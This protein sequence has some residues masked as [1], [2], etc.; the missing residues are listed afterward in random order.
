MA[1]EKELESRQAG[2]HEIESKGLA[3]VRAKHFAAPQIEKMIDSLTSALLSVKD[4]ASVRRARLQHAVDSHEYYTEAA[5]AEQWI[6]DQMLVAINQETGRDQASAEGYL[7][8]LTVLDKGG[9]NTTVLRMWLSSKKELDRLRARCDSLQDHQDANQIAARQAKLETA[10]SDLVNECNRR[11]TQLVDAGR[12]H[13]FVRQVDDLSDWL[14]EK[15]HLASSE[16]YGRD[17]EDCVQLTEKFE[18]VVRELAAAGERVAGVQRTQ[19]E[20]LRSGHPYA[21]SI[22]AKGT[23]L[24]SLWT[25]VNEA[26]T[27]RQQAL[28]GARQVHRFDQEADE[29]LNWLQDKEATGVAMEN[30]DLAHADLATIKIQMQRHEEFVHGMRAVEKQVAELC[31][32]AE[33]LWTAFPNTREHLEVRKMDME[34]QLKDILEGTRRHHE[35]LQQME[36]LQS[37][38][39]MQGR[40]PHIDEFTRQGKHMIQG[41]HVLSQEINEKVENLERS[42]AVLL[43]SLE[44]RVMSCTTKILIAKDGNRMLPSS[45]S[46][47]W[48]H[49]ESVENAEANLRDF[50]DFLVTLDAQGDRCEMVKRLT[51]IEQSFSRLRRKEV[52]RSR[53]AEED[54]RRRRYNQGD[55]VVVGGPSTVVASA[56]NASHISAGDVDMRKTPSFT[57]RRGHSVSRNS[58]SRWEDL[59]AI[60][61]RGFVDRKQDLQSGSKRATI[62]SWK[63]YYTILCGQLMCFF[64][65]ESSFYENIAAAPPVYIYGARCEP[66]PEYVKRKHAF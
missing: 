24:Q 34:E 63:N 44:G 29:T 43:R 6:K 66:F 5:E 7:R 36:S 1:L 45:S 33:R 26:A 50:D 27:E 22:R 41:G 20:L 31:R 11:R 55:S 39:Q 40:K 28:A 49:I 8:R 62:R 53:I 13:R 38:F 58:T 65:D 54:Q 47:D 15:E 12:Y 46:D 17:L 10:Y 14:H 59:G 60:D 2:I 48:R 4:A 19:E 18:T 42:W 61:M 23:D 64:K 3:M 37:Y 56:V 51:L 16:D 57:T 52:E 25:S 35:R 32:E 9:E 30:E 21:A